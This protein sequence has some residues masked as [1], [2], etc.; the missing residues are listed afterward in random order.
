MEKEIIDGTPKVLKKTRDIFEKKQ[1]DDDLKIKNQ[2]N[3]SS[4]A[5]NIQIKTEEEEL[6]DLTKEL[7]NLNTDFN[8]IDSNLPFEKSIKIKKEKNEQNEL[9]KEIISNKELKKMR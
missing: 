3:S 5:K 2:T 4:T 7:L 6:E 8:E 9:T 1:K